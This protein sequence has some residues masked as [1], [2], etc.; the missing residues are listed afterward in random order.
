VASLH[1]AA[2]Q[3]QQAAADMRTA[4]HGD[5]SDKWANHLEESVMD[6]EAEKRD[7]ESK[8]RLRRAQHKLENEDNSELAHAMQPKKNTG[9][10]ARNAHVIV[11]P[12]D[13]LPGLQD[14]LTNDDVVQSASGLAI[15]LLVGVVVFAMISCQKSLNSSDHSVLPGIGKMNMVESERR[16]MGLLHGIAPHSGLAIYGDDA[17]VAAPLRA[18]SAFSASKGREGYGIFTL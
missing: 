17:T 18:R 7:F 1:T 12:A 6:L 10:L 9:F 15:F 13:Q 4:A 14:G 5:G 16:M 2:K 3:V 11:N 8:A